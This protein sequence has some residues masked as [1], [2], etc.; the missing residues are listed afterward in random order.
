MQSPEDY[1]H[2][3]P[4]N[5]LAVKIVEDGWVRV[6]GRQAND[7][8]ADPLGP[9]VDVTTQLNKLSFTESDRQA[10]L[11]VVEQAIPSLGKRRD[12]GYEGPGEDVCDMF[13]GLVDTLRVPAASTSR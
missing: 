9:L 5:N 1:S 12:D 6:P 3:L 7:L 2:N 13:N 8:S 4:P 11:A 10:I